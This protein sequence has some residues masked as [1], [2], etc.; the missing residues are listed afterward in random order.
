MK[1]GSS[2]VTDRID[3]GTTTFG[4][5]APDTRID[6]GRVHLRAE[7]R[8]RVDLALV[9]RVLADGKW[10]GEE[11]GRDDDGT[12]RLATDLV[13]G[14]GSDR[15][16]TF[17]RSMIVGLGQPVRDA[18]GWVVPL[19]WQSAALTPLF[20][21]FVGHLRF[22]HEG[23]VIDGHYA[24]PFGVIGAALDR[25]LLGIAARATAKV[26]LTRFVNAVLTTRA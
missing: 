3:G 11:L 6:R 1:D 19:E 2:A 4:E 25:A 8:A 15:P 24:P 21:V 18:D 10:L 7:T 14:V 16:I 20:P 12:R 22:G 5:G 26:L 17:H 9:P 23:A 13:L